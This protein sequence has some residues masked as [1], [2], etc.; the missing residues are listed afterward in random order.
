[1]GGRLACGRLAGGVE[2]DGREGRVM[3][4]VLVD[5]RKK[6]MWHC[7]MNQPAVL[8]DRQAYSVNMCVL[9]FLLQ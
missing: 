9:I 8:H 6:C 5:M 4:G 3:G 2:D 1:M 7:D